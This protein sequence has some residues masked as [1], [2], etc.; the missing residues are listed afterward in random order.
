MPTAATV[1][2]RQSGIGGA[3]TTTV[4]AAT[5]YMSSDTATFDLTGSF[6]TYNLDSAPNDTITM[7]KEELLGHFE[8]MYTMRRMEITCDNEYKARAIRGFCHLYDGR[9]L[10][11]QELIQ[12]STLKIHGLRVIVVTVLRWHEGEQLQAFWVNYL[13][14]LMDK[15]RARGGLCIFTTRH[16][17]FMVDRELLGHKFR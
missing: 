14:I 10:W 8:L 1:A 15:L 13:V 4:A 7:T 2:T 11:L 5:R 9:R 16:T 3:T 17:T 12:R 6:E